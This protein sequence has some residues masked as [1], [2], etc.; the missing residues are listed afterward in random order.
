MLRIFFQLIILTVIAFGFFSYALFTKYAWG[1]ELW[2]NVSFFSAIIA[3]VLCLKT[4]K[5]LPDFSYLTSILKFSYFCLIHAAIL[6]LAWKIDSLSMDE[7]HVVAVQN[8]GEWS[9]P[10]IGREQIQTLGMN[11]DEKTRYRKSKESLI[12]MIRRIDLN[13]KYE[14]A[15]TPNFEL[16]LNREAF[17]K[18]QNGATQIEI[19]FK[20]GFF[21]V[22][23]IINYRIL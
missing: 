16:N 14:R 19:T 9:L 12:A 13:P 7:T 3:T 10:Q 17:E 20:E 23:K 1:F 4:F 6:L 22:P 2:L 15:T 8:I 18:L 11:H 5:F 21:G